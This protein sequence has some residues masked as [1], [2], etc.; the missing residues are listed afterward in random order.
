MAKKERTGIEWVGGI[1]SMPAYVTGEADPYRSDALFWMGAEGA[2]RHRRQ[3]GELCDPS[4]ATALAEA[5]FS[6]N[7]AP[8][9][10]G[11]GEHD[12]LGVMHHVDHGV[13]E[14]LHAYSPDCKLVR[15]L[16]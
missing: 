9:L 4:R 5:V 10:M 14:V 2:G 6:S 7:L 16:R 3:A 8:P 11:Y 15:D 1:V 13:G 12:D